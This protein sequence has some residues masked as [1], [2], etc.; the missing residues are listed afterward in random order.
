MRLQ[1][2]NSEQE[3]SAVCQNWELDASP[4]RHFIGTNNNSENRFTTH[5]WTSISQ[6]WQYQASSALSLLKFLDLMWLD[7]R[8]HEL[9]C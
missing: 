8:A 7:L 3:G 4:Y 2:L 6:N 5:Y 1:T 9:N